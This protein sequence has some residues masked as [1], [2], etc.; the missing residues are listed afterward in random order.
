MT[1]TLLRE[2]WLYSY[3]QWLVDGLR[4]NFNNLLFFS[5]LECCVQPT[6]TTKQSDGQVIVVWRC[7]EKQPGNKDQRDQDHRNSKATA[8]SQ[9]VLKAI[10]KLRRE[11]SSLA[12]LSAHLSREF[13]RDQSRFMAKEGEPKLLR[14]KLPAIGRYERRQ[15]DWNSTLI[16]YFL[17]LARLFAR[18]YINVISW[19]FH[20]EVHLARPLPLG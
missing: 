11:E 15:I 5:I 8:F 1:P 10:I 6:A 20:K 4:S 9:V 17:C 3:I 12:D 14:T 16:K 7:D 13:T 18:L 19:P 2:Q